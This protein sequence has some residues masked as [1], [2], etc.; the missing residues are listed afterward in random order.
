MA[1]WRFRKPLQNPWLGLWLG[2]FAKGFGR[3]CRVSWAII[4][5]AASVFVMYTPWASC[6]MIHCCATKAS[7]NSDSLSLAPGLPRRRCNGCMC[8]K[9]VAC[10]ILFMGNLKCTSVA[11]AARRH[12]HRCSNAN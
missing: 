1:G 6:C 8:W 10:G 11:R 7:S 5:S 2:Q 9:T 4:W 12:P 3:L